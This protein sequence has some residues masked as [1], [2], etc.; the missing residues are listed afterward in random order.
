MTKTNRLNDLQ[1][2]LLAGAAGRDNGS[3]IPLPENCA[4]DTTRI[5]KAV[6]SL[7]RR[8]YVDEAPVTGTPRCGRL[9]VSGTLF[10]P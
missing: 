1:L 5:G 3:L 9:V 7:L 2:V 4:Q 10:P 6:T 8:G